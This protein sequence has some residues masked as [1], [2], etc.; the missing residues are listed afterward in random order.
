MPRTTLQEDASGHLD[1]DPAADI[2]QPAFC[3]P[4]QEIDVVI[5][6]SLKVPA[7][8]DTG[9]QIMVIRQDIAQVLGAKINHQRLIEMEGVN[10]T[11][12]WTV[13]CAEN[14]ILQIGDISLK[15]H[16][17]VVE[18]AS[19][20]LLLG[21]PF[22]QA[23]LFRFEDLPSGGV[24]VSVRDPANIARRVYLSTR[25]RIGRAP[26]VNFISTA[27]KI[28]LPS[29]WTVPRNPLLLPPADPAL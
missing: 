17:H 20:G 29:L 3:L 26:A 5:N 11:T 12:N 27:N 18:D 21:R 16:T 25:P 8:L 1:F 19:F 24:E 14:L 4:L 9:S 10:S 22:Q 2:H 6:T 15:A 28:T 23:A 7:I 13:G